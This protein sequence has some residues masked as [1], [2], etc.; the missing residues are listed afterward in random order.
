VG[1]ERQ[2]EPV[3][4]HLEPATSSF[5]PGSRLY[6]YADTTAG[7]TDFTSE[8]AYA[9]VSSRDGVRMPLDSA[10]PGSGAVATPSRVSRSF[11]TNRFYQPGLLEAEDVWLWEALVSGTTR[12]KPFSLSAVDASGTA[13]FDVWLQGA[14]ESGKPVDHHVSVSLN[15]AA[16]GEARFAGKRP[17]R[18]R[19]SLQASLLR[20]GPNELSLTSVADTGAAEATIKVVD[21]LRIWFF[22]LAFVCIGLEFRITSLR[23]AGVRPMVVFAGATLLNVVLALVVATILFA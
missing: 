19:L 17:Y 5:G 23:E 9:L 8:V 6:F 18:I 7:S 14:S 12:I 1:R 16:I 20:G 11:E 3:G 15:G 21:N 13:E 10:A 4:F 2:G 22:A